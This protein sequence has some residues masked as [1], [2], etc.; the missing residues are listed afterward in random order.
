MR[1]SG[2]IVS[3][4]KSDLASPARRI[5]TLVVDDSP[6]ALSAV[7]ALLEADPRIQIVG[8]A[9]GG[10]A[11]VRQA[12]LLRPDL[13]LADLHMP[14]Y[15]GL[16]L[17]ACLRRQFPDMCLVVISTDAGAVWQELARRHGADAFITKSRL[18]RE[19]GEALRYCL[20]NRESN[21]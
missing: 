9:D 18:P 12:E 21:R 7:C 14:E 4:S 2:G 5:R 17:V 20:K 3:D 15:S 8:T 13:V 10:E 1:Q 11:G 6:A 19:I 16:K